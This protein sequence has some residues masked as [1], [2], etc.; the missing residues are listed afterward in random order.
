MNRL[1]P[2]LLLAFC[3]FLFAC[4]PGN[5][6]QPFVLTLA[7]MNDTH[8]QFDP[9]NAELKG[10][11]FGKQGETDTLYTRF[12]GYPRLLTMAKSFQADALAK[13][14][15]IL[16]L[17]GGDAW[18]GSGYFKL[19]EGMANAELLSQFGLD[20]MALGNH[21]FDLDNQKLAR[22]I[23]GVNFPVLAANLDTRD[24]PDLR[25]AANLKPFVIYA[26]D[27]NQKSPVSDLNNLPQ[28]KQLVAVM[29]LVLEDMA[30]ISPNVGKLRFGNEVT[31]AQ[32]TVDLLRQHG[33]NQI[34]AL[35]HI[36]NQRDLA[37]AAKVNGI[38]AI[39]GGH[40]HSL[41]GDFR[42]IG[43]GNTGEYAALVTNPD[44][45]GM[46]CVVQAGSYAQAIGL[47]QVSFDAQGRVIACKGQNQL[48]A[49]RDFFAD[50]ARKQALD[51]ARSK[52]AAKFIDAQPNLVT[53]DED[54]RLRGIID[55]HY[56]PA[57]EQAFGPVIATLPAA[58]QNARRPGD[59]GSDSHGSDVAPLVAEGQYYWANTPA[60][61]AL[62]GGPVHF[63]L[64]AVGGVRAD[65][66]AGELREGD[67]AL[68]LLP[69]KNQLSVLTLTGA[70]V[71][72]LLTETITATL[73]ASAHAGKFPYGGHLRYTFTETTPGK[74]GALTQLQWQDA[75]GQWQDLVDATRYRVVM[76]AYSANGNDGWQALARAQA[77]HAERQDLAWQDGKL[78]AFPVERVEQS[79][80]QLSARYTAG[81]QL[82][83]KASGL[84]CGTDAA[85][86]VQY[87]REQRPTLTALAEETVTLVRAAQ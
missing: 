87:V 37:L 14:Q 55:S 79:G 61:Q 82:D 68:T 4:Q 18:Q 44:G 15:P 60:V 51:E 67:A 45:V 72:A 34:V 31:S 23:Q 47:A 29:G 81:H 58:L 73:P 25:H 10:P 71:R 22:F 20:A 70:E 30:N 36:G 13:N 40:S 57:L 77:Q 8:S 5:E 33:I 16:L 46:T 53:V 75:D 76:N 3:S 59:N 48:L 6:G 52:Q 41:L 32:A 84:D 19:N 74:R 63:A 9:V 54:P 80:D 62:T 21:E 24:D 38:D 35:T 28:G 11:I 50:P 26:F 2:L 49:S 65:L 17:H 85:S 27:G 43:W 12:G 39:V 7:H 42:N 78:T 1:R 86:F 64:L 83:C 66:P 69:F 56:K